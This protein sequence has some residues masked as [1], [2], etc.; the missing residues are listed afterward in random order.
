VDEV[1]EEQRLQALA[2]LNVLDTPREQRFDRIVRLAARLLGAPTALISLVDEDRQFHKA[3]VGFGGRTEIPRSQSFCSHAIEHPDR[4]LVVTDPLGDERFRDNPLVTQEGGIRF[5]AGQPLHSP[6]GVAVGALCVVDSETREI[7]QDELDLLRELADLVETE[8][9]RTDEIDRA[10]DIQRRL[11]P[12]SSPSLPGYDVAAVCLSASAVGG[13]FYDWYELGDELQVVLADVMG[14]GLP[15]ALIAASVRALLRGASRY[16]DVETTVNRVAEAAED[17]LEE[18]ATFV[19][20][21]V[22]RLHPGSGVVQWVDA[23]HGIAGIITAAGQARQ[24]TS[25]GVPLGVPGLEPWR[26]EVVALAPGDTLVAL[27]DGS[28]DLFPDI[29]QAREAIRETV[30][31]AGSAQEIVDIVAAYSREH[32]ATDDVTCVVIRREDH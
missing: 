18:T 20:A 19:T 17:D 27:S 2:G 11:L 32:G 12:R 16:N 13:D 15:A 6:A 4:P 26:A 14:K 29:E 28:L 8:L 31:S 21:F 7:S 25:E 3:E 30:V 10:G 1:A 5:Y 22:A 9:A 23:G 24:F